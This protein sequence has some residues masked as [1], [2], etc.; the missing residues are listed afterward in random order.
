MSLITKKGVTPHVF[1][2]TSSM[3]LLE[4]G[5]DIST[6]AIWIGYENIETTHK[7]MVAD[8]RLIEKSLAKVPKHIETEFRYKLNADILS[9]LKYSI[10]INYVEYSNLSDC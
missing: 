10:N 7:Y 3:H 1:R 6:I 2:H 4:A 9:F 5:V 8:L